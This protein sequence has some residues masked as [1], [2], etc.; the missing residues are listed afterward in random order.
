MDLNKLV[1][2]L[3][4]NL[5]IFKTV[6]NEI[7]GEFKLCGLCELLLCSISDVDPIGKVGSD[8]ECWKV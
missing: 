7:E 6:R 2:K 3:L 1:V 8:I 4:P 5:W